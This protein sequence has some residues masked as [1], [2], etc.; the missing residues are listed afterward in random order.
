MFWC[1]IFVSWLQHR[2]RLRLVFAIKQLCSLFYTL[3]FFG[4]YRVLLS[5][6]ASPEQINLLFNVT[7]TVVTTSAF[8]YEFNF[9]SQYKLIPWVKTILHSTFVMPSISVVL[10]SLGY[11]QQGLHLNMLF[12]GTATLMLFINCFTLNVSAP[13]TSHTEQPPYLFSRPILIA[14]YGVLCIALMVNVVAAMGLNI[15]L[16]FELHNFVLHGIISGFMMTLLLQIRA[17]KMEQSVREKSNALYL[18]EKQ[19]VLDQAKRDEQLQFLHMLTHELKTPLS[20]IDLVLKSSA[21]NQKTIGY[22]NRAVADMKSIIERCVDVD[23]LDEGNIET[24]FTTFN[25]K[26]LILNILQAS[27]LTEHRINVDIAD[28]LCIQSDPQYV[29]TILGN[30]IENAMRYGSPIHPIHI[31]THVESD[32]TSERLGICIANTPATAGWPDSAQVFNKYYRNPKTLNIS[33]TGLGLFLVSRLATILGGRCVY[34]PT[35]DQVRFIL[36]IPN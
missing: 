12:V 15:G 8:W 21:P 34:A 24:T 7:V 4:Y 19:L 29:R 35:I 1:W 6:V 36:W 13:T 30:L 28:D 26:A 25:I 32:E 17:Y 10:I 11:A 31:T 3:G 18:T 9:V 14:Y 2:D 16:E 27:P 5:D 22:A 20:V 23:R 33:G